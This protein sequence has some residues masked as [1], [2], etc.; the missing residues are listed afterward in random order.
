MKCKYVLLFGT[1]AGT[2][3]C[4]R[5]GEQ[6]SH[7]LYFVHVYVRVHVPGLI[8]VKWQGRSKKEHFPYVPKLVSFRLC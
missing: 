4:M 1:C 5:R 7:V 8:K 2:C 3:T 6:S